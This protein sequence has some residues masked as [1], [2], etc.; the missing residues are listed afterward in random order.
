M[1]LE[2]FALGTG[3]CHSGGWRHMKKKTDFPYHISGFLIAFG[4]REDDGPLT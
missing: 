3:F 4:E 1:Y 2:P